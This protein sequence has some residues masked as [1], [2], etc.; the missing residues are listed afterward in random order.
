M[1]LRIRPLLISV[2]TLILLC[3]PLASI[4]NSRQALIFG[5]DQYAHLP[6]LE[7]AG[8]DAQAISDQ[9]TALGFEV[10]LRLN[11]NQRQVYR[12]LRDFENRL[13]EG[14]TGVVFFAGHGIQ[15]DGRNYLIPADAQVEIEDDLEAEAIDAG[16]ILESMARAGNP[17]NILI[18]DACRD[19]PLPKRTRSASR[20]LTITSI[21]SGAKGT[22]ILY[23]AGEG[24]VAQDGPSGGHG[25]FTEALLEA[26][27]T[28][29]Q[30]LEE[31]IKQ[32]TK[33]VLQ[34]TNGR[35]RPWSLSSIQGDFYFNFKIVIDTQDITPTP[36]PATSRTDVARDVWQAIK[37]SENL[38]L[39]T[40]FSTRFSDTPY[41]MAAEVRI[42]MLSVDDEPAKA[43]EPKPENPAMKAVAKVDG[44]IKFG[45]HEMIKISSG[46]FRIGSGRK[47]P[48]HQG[49]EK[50]A[51]AC[52]QKF[53]IDRYEVTFES[54]DKFANETGRDL[55][56]DAGMGRG[57][58]PVINV[59]WDDAR[60]YAAWASDK[61]GI[62]FRLPTEAEWE[63]TCRGG[64]RFEQ[65]CGSRDPNEVAVY[66]QLAT[67]PV[68][69]KKANA[70]GLYDMSGNAWEMTCSPYD[71]EASIVNAEYGG[72]EIKCLEKSPRQ[73]ISLVFR[74][75]SWES[76]SKEIRATRRRINSFK[77]A[78][79]FSEP[80][81]STL[82]FRLVAEE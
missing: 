54:Y 7:N 78:T 38:D 15:S 29:N 6:D 28:P 53:M 12:S 37:E 11:P 74:G 60:A 21:P 27:S 77:S 17:L 1:D 63:Y 57:R 26:L 34:R 71:F 30:K 8:R 55:P 47:A 45:P 41:A 18:L 67:S 3:A 46:C 52:F 69:S 80:Y 31:V 4:A 59:D 75:G 2:L 36:A 23:A 40:N 61:Y 24:Q 16:R 48:G 62:H 73:D 20:G 19:N 64:G 56:D 81:I 9:L 14:G 42:A 76:P 82:G 5:I 72:G 44:I 33:S 50:E 22:A 79:H 13:S 58:R 68:G 70:L 10:I 49:D 51:L 39:L 35:Q 66:N 65:Y 43:I 32:V 25:V